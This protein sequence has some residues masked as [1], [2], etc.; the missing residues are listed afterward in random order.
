MFYLPRHWRRADSVITESPLNAW[1]V[2]GPFSTEEDC[3]AAF[4]PKALLPKPDPNG[5]PPMLAIWCRS[6]S[7]SCCGVGSVS[8]LMGPTIRSDSLV[9]HPEAA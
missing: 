8:S 9:D 1:S 5:L 7:I 2:I 4:L 6:A 3:D